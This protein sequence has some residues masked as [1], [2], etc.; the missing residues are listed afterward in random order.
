MLIDEFENLFEEATVS[1]PYKMPM[2]NNMRSRSGHAPDG[3]DGKLQGKT[4]D[5]L[6]KP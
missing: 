1:L 6:G 2:P 4:A 3:A 5:Q